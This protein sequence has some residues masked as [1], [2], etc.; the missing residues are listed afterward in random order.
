MRRLLL[1]PLVLLLMV[2]PAGTADASVSGTTVSCGQ[3]ITASTRLAYD[4]VNCPGNG[5]T[6]GADDITLDL[7][8]HVID[9]VNAPGSEGVAVDGHSGVRITNGAVRDFFLNGVGLRDAPRSVVAN[10]RISQIGAGGVDGDASAGVLV[11]N[12][13]RSAV[14]GSSVSNDVVSFQSDGVDV[15]FSPGTRVS[16]NRITRNSWK[17]MF[18]LESAGSRIEDNVFDQNQAQGLEVNL[19]SDATLVNDNRARGNGA[20]GIVVGAISR[21][22]VTDNDATGNG[23]GFFFFDLIDSTVSGNRASGNVAGILLAG[24]QFG[25][26]GNRL[27]TNDA[28]RNTEIGIVLDTAANGNALVGNVA[29]ANRGGPGIGGGIVVVDSTGNSLSGN[30]TN[31]NLAVGLGVYESSE[32]G[33]AGNVL[34]RNVAN[35]NAEHGIDAVDGTVD[36]GGNVAHHNTP[37]PDCLGVRCS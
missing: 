25:S 19:G 9:G 4:L 28:S 2:V 23:A 29:N 16:G 33:A 13:P 37:A 17:G 3:T 31:R 6:V 30:V 34:R 32:G 36:G 7:G 21:G 1:V 22:R 10:L 20:D 8:G 5:L 27:V 15:L 12:S 18:V 14:T 35:N 26:H 11:K 24:G